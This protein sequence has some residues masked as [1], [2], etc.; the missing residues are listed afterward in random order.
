MAILGV[1]KKS[2]AP[3]KLKSSWHL[4]YQN[5]LFFINGIKKGNKN[6]TKPNFVPNASDFFPLKIGAR[7][8]FN[9]ERDDSEQKDSPRKITQE[10]IVKDSEFHEIGNCVYNAFRIQKIETGTNIRGKKYVSDEEFLYSPELSTILWDDTLVKRFGWPN[11]HTLARKRKEGDSFLPR[12][13][14]V[15][16]NSKF[17][18]EIPE[19]IF[20]L[21]RENFSDFAK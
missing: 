3:D 16:I 20:N 18:M 14:D 17:D 5:G 4:F 21:M 8:Q 6:Q 2:N 19:Y 10:Y 9:F 7:K 1:G 12:L 11:G 15:N 13:F